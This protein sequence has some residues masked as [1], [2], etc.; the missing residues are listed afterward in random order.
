MDCVICRL[1]MTSSILDQGKSS[2]LDRQEV[3]A[4]V[5][6]RLHSGHALVAKVAS[7]SI[8]VLGVIQSK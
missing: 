5:R 7:E 3:L 6:L 2:G 4:L 8:K 1:Q